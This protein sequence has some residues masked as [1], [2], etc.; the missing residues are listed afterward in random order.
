MFKSLK[1][2]WVEVNQGKRKHLYTPN[3]RKYHMRWIFEI[4]LN[5]LNFKNNN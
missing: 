5:Y 1:Q 4:S 3:K 2:N